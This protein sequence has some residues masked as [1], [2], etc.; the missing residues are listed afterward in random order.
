MNI[1]NQIDQQAT[2]EKE[3]LEL[4]KHRAEAD[5]VKQEK[6]EKRHKEIQEFTNNL[7]QTIQEKLKS[8]E[9]LKQQEA[10]LDFSNREFTKYKFQLE[11]RKKQVERERLEEKQQ[12]SEKT[13]KI[14]ERLNN[15]HQNKLEEYLNKLA[16]STGFNPEAKSQ[17]VTEKKKKGMN[18][19]EQYRLFKVFL[20]ITSIINFRKN[21]G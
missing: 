10:Q 13:S 6:L 12:L 2:A 9:E 20:C 18:E 19:Q 3:R 11:N 4:E 8:K 5:L 16:S 21:K 1:I 15:D 14:Q 17:L 7:Q